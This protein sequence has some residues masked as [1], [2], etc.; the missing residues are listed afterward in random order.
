MT[1]LLEKAF[2][3]A[4]QLPELEQNVL[5]RWL[6]DEIHSEA[7]WERAFAE[8]EDV[9]EML[10]YEAT[11]EKRKGNVSPLDLARL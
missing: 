9:L 11:E 1:T 4:S 10:A 6:L 3:E 5:A 7:R 8:S 2:V